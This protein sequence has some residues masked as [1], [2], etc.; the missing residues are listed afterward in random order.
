MATRSRLPW[1]ESLA[2]YGP[3]DCRVTGLSDPHFHRQQ[4]GGRVG[5]GQGGR[6]GGREEAR[7][8]SWRP[9]SVWVPLKR[10]QPAERPP[11]AAPVDGPAWTD[12][13]G[14]HMPAPRCLRNSAP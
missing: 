5:R 13:D 6:G 14:K 10:S 12:A 7:T 3:W 11:D 2:G 9:E 4:R 1:R 8:N